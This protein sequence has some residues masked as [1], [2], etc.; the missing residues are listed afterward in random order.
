MKV[1]GHIAP[2]PG[3]GPADGSAKYKVLFL[4]TNNAGGT[5]AAVIALNVSDFYKPGDSFSATVCQGNYDVV[6][7]DEQRIAPWQET[8]TH[9]VV[10][11]T[12][13][14]EVAASA[15]DGVQL[16]PRAMASISGEVPGMTHDASCPAGGPRVQVSILRE[17]DGQFQSAA[18]VPQHVIRRPEQSELADP[19]RASR[20]VS[21][22]G[23]SGSRHHELRGARHK[24]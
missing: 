22:T 6:L 15:I 4:S 3:D 19:G 2:L 18:S 16:T 17:G 10:F 8:P 14:I 11:D 5:M 9:K 1:S 20:K 21:R 12:R 23:D 7:S 13:N 24:N